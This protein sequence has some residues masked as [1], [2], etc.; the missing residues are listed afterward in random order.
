M[1]KLK[2]LIVIILSSALIS[3]VILLTIFGISLYIGWQER[4]SAKLHK[5]KV[6]A[7]NAKSYRD[8]I[9]IDGLQ[10]R[11]EEEGI[12]KEK[13]LLVGA[14][15]NNGY[16]TISSLELSVEFLN[17]SDI[18]IF[19]DDFLPLKASVMPRKTTIAALSL[20][21]SGK[22]SP[23]LPGE[24]LRFKY[25]MSEQKNKNIVSPIKDRKYATNPNEWSGKL[26]HK[27][28][29]IRF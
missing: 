19:K 21:T 1:L 11:Y 16:R 29:G 5:G 18:V 25:V 9:E 13:C 24:S 12:Y 6:A 20:F 4:E 17:T 26:I 28:T 15:K 27:V 2:S 10:A 8:L 23:L 14:I 7:L 22:E 3:S